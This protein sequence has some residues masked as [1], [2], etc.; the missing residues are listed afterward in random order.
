MY[1]KLSFIVHIH[2]VCCFEFFFVCVV[3]NSYLLNSAFFYEYEV[4]AK[5][6][7]SVQGM[8]SNSKHALF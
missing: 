3:K 8:T 7:I 1:G 6:F 2:E 4:T 5:L